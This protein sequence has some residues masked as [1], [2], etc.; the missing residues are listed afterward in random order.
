MKYDSYKTVKKGRNKM[1]DKNMLGKVLALLL[2]TFSVLTPAAS[3][4]DCHC[5][6]GC[7][8]CEC[9]TDCE[10][11]TNCELCCNCEACSGCE[12]CQGCNCNDGVSIP[13]FPSVVLPVG[14][15]LGI[16]FIMSKRK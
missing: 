16:M 5:C 14:A 10:G 15:V 7:T 6:D 12:C 11:C 9:C 13:E 8:G 3:A 1:M 4:N 2:V